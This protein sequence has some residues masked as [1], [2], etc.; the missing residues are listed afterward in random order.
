MEERHALESADDQERDSGEHHA[1]ITADDQEGGS[2]EQHVV[3]PAATKEQSIDNQ[4][5]LSK[6]DHMRITVMHPK[7][8]TR[9][10]FGWKTV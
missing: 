4:E 9:T 2:G 1:P 6:A 3:Q 7:E 5:P 8:S 10:H